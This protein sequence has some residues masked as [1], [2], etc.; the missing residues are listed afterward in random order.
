[1]CVWVCVM[2]CA[3]SANNVTV[4]CFIYAEWP[5]TDS[6]VAC[7]LPKIIRLVVCVCVLWFYSVWFRAAES[8]SAHLVVMR[9]LDGLADRLLY[10]HIHG[11]IFLC[12]FICQ[13]TLMCS[14]IS[15]RLKSNITETELD[16][17]DILN[18]SF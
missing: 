6:V 10:G 4:I 2:A 5:G 8:F 13:H 11:N 7:R 16:I 17:R 14:H 9:I 15:I 3:G 18:L 12:L 1:M